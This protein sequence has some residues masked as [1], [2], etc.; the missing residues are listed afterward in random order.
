MTDINLSVTLR[1]MISILPTTSRDLFA[2]ND[3]QLF[4]TNN[5]PEEITNLADKNHREANIAL[6]M[7]INGVMNND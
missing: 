4:D 5:D 1:P 2:S 3:I 6:I 7:R